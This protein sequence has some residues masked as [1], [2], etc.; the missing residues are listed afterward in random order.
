ML[1][2]RVFA[3]AN[4]SSCWVTGADSRKGKSASLWWPEEGGRLKIQVCLNWNKPETVRPARRPDGDFP[5]DLWAWVPAATEAGCSGTSWSGGPRSLDS[6]TPG[7]GPLS[8]Q[9]QLLWVLL[10]LG[11]PESHPWDGRALPA[12]GPRGAIYPAPWE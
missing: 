3:E 12:D 2:Y 4:Q 5:A 1:I 11:Q 7:S 10:S 9:P 8:P 6:M